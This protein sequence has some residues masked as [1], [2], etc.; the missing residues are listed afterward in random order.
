MKYKQEL[1]KKQLALLIDPDRFDEKN[2]SEIISNKKSSTVDL[3]LIGGSIVC[4]NMEIVIDIIRAYCTIPI[5]IFPGDVT[6]FTPK[7]DGILFLSLISGRNSQFLI[8]NHVIISAKI[9]Q[10]KIDVIPVG[11][12]LVESGKTTSVEYMSNTKPIPSDKPEIVVATAIAGELLGLKYIYLE[13]GSGAQLKISETIVKSVK[14]NINIPLIVGGGVRDT[15]TLLQLYNAGADIVVV[16]TAV[17]KNPLCLPQFLEVR[18]M[19]NNQNYLNG[20][21][22]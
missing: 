11:Y 8:G 1:G 3:I 5:Y 7:A 15:D 14:Q 22:M 20:V 16:G 6:Q 17:E 9:K 21:K 19:Y 10:S 12:I 13:G 18:D 4:N 2:I